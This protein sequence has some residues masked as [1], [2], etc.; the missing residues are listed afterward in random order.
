M[1]GLSK[2]HNGF[3]SVAATASLLSPLLILGLGEGLKHAGGKLQGQNLALATLAV[4]GVSCLLMV[5]G[6]ILGILSLLLMRPGGRTSIVV[7]SLLGL[8]ATGVM[9]AMAVPNYLQVRARVQSQLSAIKSVQ[10]A[11]KDLREPSAIAMTNQNGPLT[12]LNHSAQTRVSRAE[13]TAATPAQP[14]PGDYSLVMKAGEAYVLRMQVILTNYQSAQDA[15]IAVQVL[16]TSNLTNRIMIAERE[17]IVQRFEACNA[18]WKDFLSHGEDNFR[19]EMV[20]RHVS[21]AGM[22]SALTGFEKSPTIQ[23]RPLMEE[24]L[25][26]DDRA[27]EATLGVLGLL[28][29]SWGHW[30]YATNSPHLHFENRALLDQYNDDLTVIREAGVIQSATRRQLE[31]VIQQTAAR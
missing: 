20:A 19:A 22:A 12:N 17:M 13:Q 24:I 10:S 14:A 16:A 26:Q 3:A 15:M 23:G 18:A 31:S 9:V 25:T 4:G 2:Y 29:A 6:L 28:D 27:S 11:F 8:T 30:H 21:E 1:Y 7:R 5:T